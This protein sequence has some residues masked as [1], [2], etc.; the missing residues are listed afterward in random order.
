[1]DRRKPVGCIFFVIIFIAIL[2]Y[3]LYL[4]SQ[5]AAAR[6]QNKTYEKEIKKIVQLEQSET[7]NANSL[8]LEKFFTY[9]STSERYEAVKPLMTVEG[10]R[11]TFP[12]GNSLPEG[13]QTV[14]SVM[15]DL[16]AYMYPI[17]KTEM[18]FI[19]EFDITTE[20]NNSSNKQTVMVRTKL[21]YQQ[22]L[23]WKVNEVEF[24]GEFTGRVKE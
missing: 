10:Y 11:S 22:A 12:S 18:E 8:F 20:F 14:S 23:G 15:K 21:E 6:D 3:V 9:K 16:K 4:W 2:V 17:T 13:Q 5:L 7:Y 19:N 1:M 24:I